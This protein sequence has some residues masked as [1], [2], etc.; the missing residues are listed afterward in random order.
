MSHEAVNAPQESTRLIRDRRNAR[1]VPSDDGSA[2][3]SYDASRGNGRDPGTLNG[4]TR[5]SFLPCSRRADHVAADRPGI[6]CQAFADTGPSSQKEK[7][8]GRR[9][10]DHAELGMTLSGVPAII[11]M[12]LRTWGYP[13]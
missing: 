11:C 12:S 6:A 8:P 9:T 4:E 3:G 5:P 1:V 2:T 7:M 13:P 10:E